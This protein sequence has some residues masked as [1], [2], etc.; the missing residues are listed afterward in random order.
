MAKEVFNRNVAHKNIG[1]IETKNNIR[2]SVIG[3]WNQM[4]DNIENKVRDSYANYREID[5]TPEEKSVVQK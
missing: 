5:T 3:F 2:G 1:E 4:A